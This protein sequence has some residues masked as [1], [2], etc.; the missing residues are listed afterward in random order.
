MESRKI[1]Q[2]TKIVVSIT[3]LALLITS[4]SHSETPT[5]TQAPEISDEIV[6]T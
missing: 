2:K 3:M 5:N 1:L 4:C 6:V